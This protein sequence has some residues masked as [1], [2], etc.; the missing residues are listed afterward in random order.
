MASVFKRTRWVNENGEKVPKDTP[1]AKQVTSKYW[2]VKVYINGKPRMFKGYTDKAASLQ[3]GARMERRKAQGEQ[4]LIDPFGEHRKRPILEH[5]EDWLADAR[6]KGRA[7]LYVHTL[8][9]RL[10]RMIEDN[11]WK[12]L[13]DITA[14]SF[15]RWREKPVV[16]HHA[17]SENRTVG[18]GTLNQ[19][20]EALRTFCIWCV[21]RGR[22]ASNPVA[23]V[24]KIDETNDV[25]RERRAVTD[26]EINRLLAVA[27]ADH[28][29]VYRF[30]LA[31]GLRR[32]ELRE[33]EWGDLHLDAIPGA[34]VAL[35]AQSTKARRGESLP[36]RKDLTELLRQHRGDAENSDPVFRSIP[37][38]P[39]HK[40]YLAAAGIPFED[41]QGRRFDL[42]ALRMQF[43]TGLNRAGV[44]IRTAM[45]LARHTDAKLTL[46]TYTDMGVFDLAA[47]VEKLPAVGVQPAAAVAT[48]TDPG[49]PADAGRTFCVTYQ[50]AGLGHCKAVIGE[51]PTVNQ[52]SVNPVTGGN[53]QTKTP[54]GEGGGTV[55]HLGLEPKTR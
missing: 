36:I 5:I 6:A 53:W 30:I 16:E 9:A 34:Y 4:G 25:R 1:G 2:I 50:Q 49:T 33:L 41:E 43:I 12:T 17:Q 24:E 54:T 32:K 40:K 39:K 31:T 20:F 19:Y 29:L 23:T 14:D 26:D 8:G 35:R 45:A 42:H 44:P 52:T 38:M 7:P 13:G 47:A 22:M 15:C 51:T 10:R 28:G 46:R 21:K 37:S 3:M 18:P 55:R 48:G 27:R 11:G